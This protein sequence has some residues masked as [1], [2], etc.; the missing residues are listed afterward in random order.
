MRSTCSCPTMSSMCAAS[1]ALSAKTPGVGTRIYSFG[2]GAESD[3]PDGCE[4]VREAI[5]QGATTWREVSAMTGISHEWARQLGA[6]IGVKP[7][8]PVESDRPQSAKGVKAGPRRRKRKPQWNAPEIVDRFWSQV[9]QNG[10]YATGFDQ[11]TRCWMWQGRTD[12]QNYGV[13]SVGRFR[14]S[15][16]RYSY[17]LHLSAPH[18]PSWTTYAIR[19][20]GTAAEGRCALIGYALILNILRSSRRGRMR[21]GRLGTGCIRLRLRKYFRG[22]D[23]DTRGASTRRS[24]MRRDG[25]FACGASRASSRHLMAIVRRSNTLAQPGAGAGGGDWSGRAPRRWRLSGTRFPSLG[26][27]KRLS[28]LVAAIDGAAADESTGS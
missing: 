26:L 2:V 20:R 17:R 23:T 15:A 18:G 12:A 3:R 8:K 22:V 28:T 4:A 1:D 27:L 5:E 7:A 21:G 13:L 10:P 14:T 19:T 6:R 25:A 16:H 9:E 11:P 24:M